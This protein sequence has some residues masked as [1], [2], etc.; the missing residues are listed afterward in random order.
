M[1][2]LLIVSKIWRYKLATLPILALALVGAFYEVALKKPIYD[3]ASSYILV[4]PPAPP[5]PDEI[6]RDPKLGVGSNN[7]YTRFSDQS[8]VVQ[9]LSARL[10]SPQARLRLQQQG[11][12]P[13]YRVAPD[14]S[15]GFTAPIV[16]ITGTGTT[17]A[18]A[19]RTANVVGRALTRE[20]AQMQQAHGVTQNYRIT[21]Q[22][23]VGARQATLKASGNLR[24]VVA[25]F[26]LGAVMLFLVISVLDAVSILMRGKRQDGDEAGV[27]ER[28]PSQVPLR[29]LDGAEHPVPRQAS[30]DRPKHDVWVPSR[31][32]AAAHGAP[33]EVAGSDGNEDPWPL[34]QLHG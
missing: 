4:N 21:S 33:R 19:V 12:D 5:S 17:P 3:T 20:L 15:F 31:S 6:A 13:R 7:P 25:V 10:D 11:A 27:A 8:I 24:G 30:E 28:P 29:D 34:G 2:L 32:G 9:V 18:E 22:L 23:L 14:V 26:A 16:Q 1:S